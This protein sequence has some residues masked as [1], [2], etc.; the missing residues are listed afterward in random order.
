M[1]IKRNAPTPQT[2]QLFYKF[3][4]IVFFFFKHFIYFY[5]YAAV[6]MMRVRAHSHGGHMEVRGYSGVDP[7]CP[8]L[9]QFWGLNSSYHTFVSK[10]LYLVSQLVSP[11]FW[12]NE[13][14]LNI[15]KGR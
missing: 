1:L 4:G 7:P 13:A 2:L 8:S 12:S 14:Y 15:Y 9:C 5:Y 6:C 10:Y 3:V 11:L